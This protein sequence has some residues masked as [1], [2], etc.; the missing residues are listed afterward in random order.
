MDRALER[1][2][3]V[4]LEAEEVDR[5]GSWTIAWPGTRARQVLEATRSIAA[6]L[7]T[8][9]PLSE[10]L[11]ISESVLE[12]GISSALHRVG[13]R[14]QRGEGVAEAFGMERGWFPPFY[15]GAVRAGEASGDLAA[16]FERLASHLER[17]AEIR[18]SVASSLVYPG[19]LA[20]GAGLSVLVILFV[21]LPRFSDLLADAGAHLPASTALLV[22]FSDSLRESWITVLVSSATATAGTA[23]FLRHHRGRERLNRLFLALP[24]VGGLRRELIAAR[25]AR[26][27][28]ILLRGGAPVLEA[29]E[30][31][32]RSI[33]DASARTELARARARVREGES[34]HAA[35]AQGDVFPDLLVRLVA[36]GEESGKV[37]EFLHRAA[38][39][40][41]RRAERKVDRMV[42]LVEPLMIVLFG[43]IV[44]VV[45]LALLQAIYGMNAGVFR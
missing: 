15:V 19:V 35:L 7:G 32:E 45:A 17:E 34:L 31:A 21:V 42:V 11:R 16:A 37:A 12:E 25:F 2:G 41:E 10:T 44:S 40:F 39:V 18:T 28:S 20:L 26:L 14:L 9:L 38:D 22:T 8:G 36:V 5:P 3:L 23:A 27:A 4:L 29:L 43:G 6:L 33:A 24:V 30:G 1:Q 13:D